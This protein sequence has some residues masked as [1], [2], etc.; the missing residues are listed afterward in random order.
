MSIA[1]TTKHFPTRITLVAFGAG[2]VV[3]SCAVGVTP[4]TVDGGADYGSVAGEG[5][6]QADPQTA[7]DGGADAKKNT[8]AANRDALSN[9]EAAPPPPVVIDAAIACPGY[10]L[11]D[12][13]ATCHACQTS[14]TTCQRNGCFNGYY[15]ELSAQ[16]CRAKP[17]GC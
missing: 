13:T 4:T 17:S 16:K 11:P 7:I 6:G 1:V 10:A 12:E 9:A 15:C 14:S 2:V 8:D 3:T 5:E